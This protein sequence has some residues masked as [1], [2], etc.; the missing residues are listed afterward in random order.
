MTPG[1]RTITRSMC[2]SFFC[3]LDDVRNIVFVI[4]FTGLPVSKG[5]VVEAV[6]MHQKF[7]ERAAAEERRAHNVRAYTHVAG[8]ELD[9]QISETTHLWCV[10]FHHCKHWTTGLLRGMESNTLGF[11]QSSTAN[12]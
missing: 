6:A 12:M 5:D 10:P 7:F 11:Y 1:K 4:P 2:S 9:S 3:C 8:H